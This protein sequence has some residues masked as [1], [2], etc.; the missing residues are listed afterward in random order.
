MFINGCWCVLIVN[1]E[2][3]FGNY[4]LYYIIQCIQEVFLIDE[5][6]ITNNLNTLES[7]LNDCIGDGILHSVNYFD[8]IRN[9]NLT[10]S[11][12]IEQQMIDINSSHH[13]Q[14]SDDITFGYPYLENNEILTHQLPCF[15]RLDKYNVIPTQHSSLEVEKINI[16][17]SEEVS[18]IFNSNGEVIST[19]L[20]GTLSTSVYSVGI[21]TLQFLLE[22]EDSIVPN[23]LIINPKC[24]GSLQDAV[25]TLFDPYGNIPV[26]SYQA[27]IKTYPIMLKAHTINNKSSLTIVVEYSV[28][29][30][31]VFNSLCCR[32]PSHVKSIKT[33]PNEYTVIDKTLYIHVGIDNTNAKQNGQFR[34]TLTSDETFEI[35]EQDIPFIWIDFET[36]YLV[37][38]LTV[39]GVNQKG[40]HTVEQS[41][42]VHCKSG[43]Y[44]IRMIE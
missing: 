11:S 26:C 15:E 20:Y 22:G 9:M 4:E 33:I 10:L 32:I 13:L 5:F 16:D 41:I 44:G 35:K 21:N 31:T 29:G 12:S 27:M 34:I 36:T 28:C 24:K 25:F 37:S 2:T 6:N 40:S 39:K 1:N 8:I 17:H 23:T 19:K 3:T 43:E 7:I 42:K 38:S 18:I 30:D 14:F